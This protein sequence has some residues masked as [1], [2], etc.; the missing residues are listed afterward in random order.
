MNFKN[1]INFITESAPAIPLNEGGAAGH[2]AHIFDDS[3]MSFGE[4]KKLLSDIFTGKIELTEKVDGQNITVTFKDNQIYLSR[5]VSTIK[6]PMTIEETVEKFS[7]RPQYIQD[8]FRKSL[9]VLQKAFRKLPKE[10][11]DEIFNNGQ[12]FMSMEIVYPPARNTIYYGD[13]AM[14]I[15]HNISKY[16]EKGH[17]ISEDPSKAKEIYNILEKAGALN[18]DEFT[19]TKPIAITIN[20]SIKASKNLDAV[21]K[22]LDKFLKKNKL[23]NSNTIQDYFKKYWTDIIETY[24]G[25]LPEDIFEILVKRYAD[26][27]KTPN[28]TAINKMVVADKSIDYDKFVEAFD[29]IEKNQSTLYGE[30][31]FPLEVIFFKAAAN[32]LKTLEG[33]VSAN[34]DETV[35]RLSKELS[36]TIDAYLG[37]PD[38]PE[39][40]LRQIRKVMAI[41]IDKIVPSE[42]IV[43]KYKDKIIKMTGIFAPANRILG[44]SKFRK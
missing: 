14:L 9:E 28:K 31:I 15:P 29:N 44:D 18:I 19:I 5:G 17:K 42:G 24:F 35:S 22:E 16:D 33:F 30:M 10:T 21:N 3:S 13:K 36:D 34:P 1:F 41:G 11:T 2:T 37:N 6:N 43:F 32:F 40:L 27:I 7:D 38:T 12:N 26:K 25:E 8:A 4:L 23:S 20:D 39:H